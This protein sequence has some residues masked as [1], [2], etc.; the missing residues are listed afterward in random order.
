MKEQ[1]MP[2]ADFFTSLVLLTFGLSIIV[3]SYKMPTL[4]EQSKNIYAAPGIVP[5][6]LGIIISFLSLVLFFR[7]IKQKG[8]KIVIS[9]SILKSF[10]THEQT[11]RMVKT[12]LICI[13]YTLLLG[14]L[15]FILLTFLFV[16]VFI[17]TFEYDRNI[18]LRS[19]LRKIGIALLL[20]LLTALV[21]YAVFFYVFLVNLP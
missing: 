9:G 20:A 18:P 19:Q 1:N 12:A 5:G 7:S 3:L 17:V 16:F 13:V 4:V 15:P 6:L 21:V 2:K 10:L 8:Y 14:H 11:N